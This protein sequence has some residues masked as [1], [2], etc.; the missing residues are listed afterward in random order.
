MNRGSVKPHR[1]TKLTMSVSRHRAAERAVARRR[2]G[3]R[4][5]VAPSLLMVAPRGATPRRDTRLRTS[6]FVE[7]LGGGVGQYHA[8][9]LQHVAAVGDASAMS[10]FCSTSRIVVPCRLIVADR[11]RRSARR[12]SARGPSTAR[13]AAGPGPRHEGAADRQHLLLA[14]GQ[15]AAHLRDPLLQAR[16][17][18]EH[19][20]E[21]LRRC[22]P[23]APG[24]SAHL[25]VL[26]DGQAGEDPAALRHWRDAAPHDVVGRRRRAMRSPSK[27]DRALAG[28]SSR[29]SSSASSSCRRRWRRSARRSRPGTSARPP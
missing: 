11:S 26:A 7:Q 27:R 22:S 20:L 14:A 19:A 29:R 8:A 13:P 21:V 12:G 10:A 16:E 25:E 6:A 4:S 15:R 17:Q 3:A 1:L 5:K 9:G 2:P 18:L 23:L 24:V 28:R